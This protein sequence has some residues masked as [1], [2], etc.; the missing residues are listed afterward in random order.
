[1]YP[2]NKAAPKPFVTK[3]EFPP[4]IYQILSR[5]LICKWKELGW[6]FLCLYFRPLALGVALLTEKLLGKYRNPKAA[7]C[8]KS[9]FQII[10]RF[11]LAPSLKLMNNSTQQNLGGWRRG[12]E[13]LNKDKWVPLAQTMNKGVPAQPLLCP[14]TWRSRISQSLIVV[15]GFSQILT[16]N[17]TQSATRGKFK[18]GKRKTQ[19]HLV[20]FWS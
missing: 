11:I 2:C 19:I 16:F 17:M 6:G 14:V 20:I 4:L 7:F 10:M 12:K 3:A 8:F 5:N 18:F 9:V 15:L 1:M 13:I